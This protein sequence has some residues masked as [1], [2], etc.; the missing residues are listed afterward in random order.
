MAGKQIYTVPDEDHH[1]RL[2]IFLSQRLKDRISRSKLQRLILENDVL[3]DGR[4]Q[5][6]NY[7]VRAGQSVQVDIPQGQE[8]KLV[9]E[10]I[11]VNIVYEDDD[12]VVVDKPAGMVVHPAVGNWTGT[13]VNAL[14]HKSGKLSELGLP[15]RPGVVHRIDKDTSG[16]LVLA[17][18]DEAYLSLAKQ[19]KQRW[20]KRKYLA[21]VSGVVAQD[22]GMVEVP[23][24]RHPTN[25]K[26]MTVTYNKGKQAVSIYKVVKRYS[27]FTLLEVRLKTGRTHQIRVHMAHIGH[28]V[29]GDA[30]YSKQH[31][32]INRQALHAA[33]L[34]FTHPR[35]GK[36]VEFESPLPFDMRKALEGK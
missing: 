35:T 21:I 36:L 6:N 11:P 25:R 34:G 1:K 5:K 17:K 26:Q 30:K 14:L 13:L 7:R 28:P 27:S 3:V 24:G 22:E 20:V 29:L 10:N 15:L 8:L 9:P 31:H 16:L 23:I 2:D 18:T 33:T 32:L 12:V 19:F 4:P